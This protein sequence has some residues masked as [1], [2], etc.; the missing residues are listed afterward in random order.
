[1]NELLVTLGSL[2]ASLGNAQSS[3][4]LKEHVA[5]LNTKLQLLKE[6]IEKLEEENSRLIERNAELEKHAARQQASEEF[7][8][9]RGALFKR[10]PNGGYG[11]TPYCP[12]CHRTMSCFQRVFPYECSNKSCGHRADFKGAHLGDVLASL[13]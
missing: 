8:E 11:E 2:I 3:G 6:H 5:L 12:I 9:A 4:A 13:P 10:L 1:M 7:V